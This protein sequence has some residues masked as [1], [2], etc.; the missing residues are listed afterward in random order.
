MPSRV[1][2]EVMFTAI[3][4]GAYAKSIFSNAPLLNLY[5]YD[6]VKDSQHFY[7]VCLNIYTAYILL[8]TRQIECVTVA[9]KTANGYYLLSC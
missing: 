9:E 4:K 7:L 6:K 3:L 5:L 1:K 2:E 8:S